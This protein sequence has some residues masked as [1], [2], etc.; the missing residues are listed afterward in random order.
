MQPK[1]NIPFGVLTKRAKH[2]E[3]F[4]ATQFP[5]MNLCEKMAQ[6]AKNNPRCFLR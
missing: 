2:L 4:G 3:K 6:N 5:Q 1:V